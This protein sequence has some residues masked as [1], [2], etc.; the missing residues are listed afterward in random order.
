MKHTGFMHNYMR[1]SWGKKILEWSTSPAEAFSTTLDINN[2]YLLDGRDPNS[3]A[4]V[5]WVFGK[6]DSAW[7][8]RPIFGKIRFMAASGLERKC[9]IK[10]Y[11][12]KGDQR[13]GTPSQN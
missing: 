8:E 4:G 9:D 10:A 3:Y 12:R 13:L 5:A 11:C 1:M 2:K 6:H 7:F